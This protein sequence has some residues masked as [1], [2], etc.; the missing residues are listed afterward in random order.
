MII[1]YVFI[2]MLLF[3]LTTYLALLIANKIKKKLIKVEVMNYN[4]KNNRNYSVKE[5]GHSGLDA[6]RHCNAGKKI[7][8]VIKNSNEILNNENFNA[9]DFVAKFNKED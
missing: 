5:Q 3:L 6:V 7:E 9:I 4:N 2:G 1:L 8:L